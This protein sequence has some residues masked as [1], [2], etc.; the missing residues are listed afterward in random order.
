[1]VW[2]MGFHLPGPWCLDLE[3]S[4]WSGG[5]KHR[6]ALEWECAWAGGLG[7]LAPDV[8]ELREPMRSAG[9]LLPLTC[10]LC[11]LGQADKTVPVTHRGSEL[12]TNKSSFLSVLRLGL[13]Q[14][15][16]NLRVAL[17]SLGGGGPVF[18]CSLSPATHSA[19]Q[20]QPC[21]RLWSSVPC[22]ALPWG[23]S[24]LREVSRSQGRVGSMS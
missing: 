2:P 11:E 5:L 20:G 6:V 16:L 17:K 4:Q 7:N 22:R 13:S 21:G 24:R 18:L 23:V 14:A 12:K 19:C 15:K 10:S 1:M 9:R 8:H 3:Q